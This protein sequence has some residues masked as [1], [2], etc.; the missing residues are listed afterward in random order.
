MHTHFIVIIITATTT[1]TKNNGNKLTTLFEIIIKTEN[2][3]KEIT[4]Q[5]PLNHN[6]SENVDDFHK[7][8]NS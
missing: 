8:I 2:S 7:N 3:V 6:G 1:P 4:Q 5:R